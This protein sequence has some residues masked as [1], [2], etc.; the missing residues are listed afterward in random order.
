M[1]EIGERKLGAMLS[2]PLAGSETGGWVY[3][4]NQKNFSREFGLSG[5]KELQNFIQKEPELF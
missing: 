3:G 1:D 4:N 5:M 2:K